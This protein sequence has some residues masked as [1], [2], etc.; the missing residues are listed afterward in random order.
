MKTTLQWTD[1]PHRKL[2]HVKEQVPLREFFPLQGSS[3]VSE[4]RVV[5][6]SQRWTS[7]AWCSNGATWRACMYSLIVEGC[8][9]H[10]LIPRYFLRYSSTWHCPHGD[11][12]EARW[13]R[14][15]IWA[16]HWS[17]SENP[18]RPRVCGKVRFC[19]GRSQET[20]QWVK[21]SGMGE[22]LWWF[23]FVLLQGCGEIVCQGK[24]QVEL[25]QKGVVLFV[26]IAEPL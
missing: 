18:M 25:D 11:V 5:P 13:M 15:G 17:F 12:L 3:G 6:G 14:T 19:A 23:W 10:G 21:W 2:Q 24:Y 22:A 8:S 7:R 16:L 4:M 26:E 20:F 9:S 1:P